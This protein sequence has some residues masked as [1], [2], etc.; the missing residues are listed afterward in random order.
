MRPVPVAI[1]TAKKVPAMQKLAS[2]KGGQADRNAP[3]VQPPPIMAPKVMA[4]A[5]KKL[6]VTTR[7]FNTLGSGL[8]TAAFD[9][10]DSAAASAPPGST[11][12]ISAAR[13]TMSS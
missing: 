8:S 3:V 1:E 9:G 6:L 11:P 7:G 13:Q 10:K 12:T 4:P 2:D 5:E